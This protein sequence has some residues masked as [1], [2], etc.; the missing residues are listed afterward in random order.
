[1]SRQCVV[2]RRVM[3]REALLQLSAPLGRSAAKT[4][5]RQYA[6]I[7]VQCL[8]A[9]LGQSGL[10][11]G[12][13]ALARVAGL[14]GLARRQGDLTSG[15]QALLNRPPAPQDL[16]FVASDCAERTHKQLVSV[17]APSTLHTLFTQSQ[18]ARATGTTSAVA[19]SIRSGRIAM[20][21]V[22]W[23]RVWY[24][25]QALDRKSSAQGVET[26]AQTKRVYAHNT[27]HLSSE[28]STD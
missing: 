28:T 27:Q 18:M 20:Q 1:M 2:C 4:T 5:R 13:L 25:A 23:L 19:L 14:L 22:Y 8:E 11:L 7:R 26:T 10:A 17:V 21:A 16:A 6:C 15:A 3:G 24:E 9:T 12:T